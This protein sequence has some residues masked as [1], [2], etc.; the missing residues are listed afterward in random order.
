[1]KKPKATPVEKKKWYRNTMAL[2]SVIGGSIAL[3]GGAIQ[4]LQSDPFKPK[5][6]WEN[7]E[8]VLDRSEAMSK[9]FENGTKWDAAVKA[10]NEALNQ[11]SDDRDN[12]ALRGFG[13]PC[14]AGNT[15]L[16]VKF[17][18]N[19][20][21]RVRD[22]VRAM[23]LGGPTTLASAVIK[24]SA[25]LDDASHF[26]DVSRRI[27]VI[28]AGADS[29]T[30][31]AAAYISNRLQGKKVNVVFRFIGLDLPADE[32]TKLRQIAERT[33]GIALPVKTEAQLKN[34]LNQVIEIEPAGSA[35]TGVVSILNAV[36][37]DLNKFINSLNEKNHSAASDNL[38]AARVEFKKTD[39]PFQDLGKRRSR[40]SF[41][42]L[43][44]LAAENRQVQSQLLTMA[45]TLNE[46]GENG[47]P[48]AYNDFVTKF[49]EL[50]QSYNKN[51]GEINDIL[52][53]LDVQAA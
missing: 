1:M 17:R 21:G 30:P 27:I 38:K 9:P 11:S 8:I 47:D 45:E 18:Q 35:T 33:G 13:G 22:A 41:Q 48:T 23:K 50:L 40:S 31:D 42:K 10:V 43:Y 39:L 36:I 44:T 51:I 25:D 3:A 12:L 53:H 34:A 52:N 49:N 6:V 14:D 24:A 29:C 20:E 46:S 19:N 7:I 15:E 37:G 2:V 28:T 16:A 4:L 5:K 32:E 26:D